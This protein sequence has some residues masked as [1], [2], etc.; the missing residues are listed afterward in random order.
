[1]ART[2]T[3]ENTG[4]TSP[5]GKG[6]S[7][8][9]GEVARFAKLAESWWDPHG[10]FRP[11]HQLNPVRLTYLRRQL[12]AHFERDSRGLKPY[13]GLSLLDVGCGGGLLSEPL[14]RLGARVTAIDA[15]A[16]AISVAS[17]HAVQSRLAI[18]Y[19]CTTAEEVAAS[20]ETFDVV[21]AMEIVEHVA[22]LG[23]FADALGHLVAPGGVLALATLNRTLKSFAFAI[24]GAEYVLRWLPRGTHNW[25]KF[26][27]PSE[28]SRHFRRS[29][30]TTSDVVGVSL[31][32]LAGEWRLSGDTTVNY[33]M[34]A[35][36]PPSD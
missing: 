20:G 24:V 16:E 34:F 4:P 9:A 2:A 26:V 19:Q 31:D 7:I 30:I 23:L 25:E 8:D 5:P 6:T 35:S 15:D 17:L 32:P 29:G 3:R 14:A 36:K 28:V 21:I 27:K 1:M 22:D 11:L 18:D 33:M 13:E 12:D 10:A